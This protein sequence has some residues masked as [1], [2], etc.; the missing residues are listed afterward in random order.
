MRPCFRRETFHHLGRWLD[1]A[2][3]NGNADMVIM[4]IGNKSD[5]E[6]RRV[7]SYDEGASFAADNGLIFLE[8]SAKT[9]S[10]VEQAFVQ[11][12]DQILDNIEKG[13]YDVKNEAHGIKVGAPL[14]GASGYGNAAGGAGG[15]GGSS[16]DGGGGGCA[17]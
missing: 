3:Q 17:C 9:A 14:P 13:I 16:A 15:A 7:V 5:M 8:T 6:D 1:E 11:T 2:R 4:L 12:A 10:N